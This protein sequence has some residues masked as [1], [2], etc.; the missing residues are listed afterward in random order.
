MIILLVMANL[1]A[2]IDL[3]LHPDIEYFDS[4]HLIVG[5]T[6]AFVLGLFL[7]FLI[8]YIVRLEKSNRDIKQAEILIQNQNKQ[9]HELNSTKDKFFSII[10]HDLKSPFMGFIGITEILKEDVE[11]FS[12]I[13]IS[14][15]GKEMNR[16]AKNLLKLLENLLD[17]AQMQKGIITYNPKEYS[18]SEIFNNN[19]NAIEQ[20]AIQKGISLFNTIA[21][22]VKIIADEKM[23]NSV[24]RNLLT[25][26]VKFTKRDGKIVVGAKEVENLMVEISVA[27]SGIGMP[28]ELRKKLFKIDEKV[29]RKG[30]DG[31]DSS[32]L[33]LLLCKEFVEKHSGK[34]RVES[35]EGTGSTFYF[36]LPMTKTDVL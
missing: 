24:I 26:S 32:G 9:L 11:G 13:E 29:G 4:E 6:T 19:L 15:L 7:V 21:D 18:L 1:G 5:L 30:T 36:T 34:I 28:E 27:D 22:S 8:M 2:V 10:A 20:T 33:G 16:N 23:I 14:C 31:E 17:W 12:R 3:I 35:Q 25:N